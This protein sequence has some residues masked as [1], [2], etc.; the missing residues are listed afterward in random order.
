[1]TCQ[2]LTE[3]EDDDDEEEEEDEE[4]VEDE[5]SEDQQVGVKIINY[6]SNLRA[7]IGLTLSSLSIDKVK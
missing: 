6:V 4:E 2:I 7:T 3:A 1:M 5:Q